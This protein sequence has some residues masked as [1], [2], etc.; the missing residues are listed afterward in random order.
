MSGQ[1][2]SYYNS[3]ANYADAQY[4]QP[5]QPVSNQNASGSSAPVGNQNA[6]QYQDP[7]APPEPKPPPQ[8]PPPTYNQAVYGFDEAFKI[9]KPK[10]NDI[11]AGLLVG[12]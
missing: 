9:E 4:Q 10:F 8:G 2:A 3:G 12:L 6:Y 1:A 5:Q 11:W 7:R